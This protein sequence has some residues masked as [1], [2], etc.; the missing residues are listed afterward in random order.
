MDFG[1]LRTLRELALRK[2][3]AAVA[4][5]LFISPSAVSQQ[6]TQLEYEAG[7]P[8]VERR[9]R[10]VKLTPAGEQLA[11]H[12]ERIIAA[13]EEAKTDLAEL[14]RIVAGELRV[15]AFPSVAAVLI[16]ATMK[17][18]R[19]LHPQLRISFDEMEPTDSLAAL[20]AWQTDVALIDNLTVPPELLEANIETI[21][22]GEDT[23]YAMLSSG[24]RC[25][26]KKVIRLGDLREESWALDRASD[27]YGSLIIRECRAAGFEPEINGNCKGFEVVLALVAAGC[28]VS[29]VP[30]LRAHRIRGVRGKV[31][32]RR[33]VPEIR[34][35]IS[36]AFRRGESRN[37]AVSALV[38]KLQER[39]KQSAGLH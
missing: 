33:I 2:T 25:A 22:I 20:R 23:L 3:M 6:I 8:L 30:G 32:V 12:A 9:G 34:R 39:A 35:K 7:V 28:S 11:M 26:A 4:E 24:S 21:A 18:L 29:V 36:I 31:V 15:A 5:A 38:Q 19:N 13:L 37:P 1:R 16:P 10:G 27:A 14:K 17:T